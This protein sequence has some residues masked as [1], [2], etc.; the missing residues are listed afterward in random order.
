M[1]RLV[2]GVGVNDIDR[3]GKSFYYKTWANML[4]R[5]YSEAYQKDRPTYKGCTVCEEWLLFSNFRDWM[6]SFSWVG[7]HLDKDI[8]IP[9]NKVYSPETCC[10]IDQK[11]N[12]LLVKCLGTKPLG[13]TLHKP[14]GK[15]LAQIRIEGVNKYLGIFNTS[16]G[17][18][19][20]YKTEKHRILMS[21]ADGFSDERIKAGLV[22]HAEIIL[23]G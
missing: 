15:Y 7:K 20:A 17:A 22:G 10:F 13:F 5:C 18:G 14:T 19:N 16:K 6:R 21:V 4:K 3:L 23:N 1:S 11:T 8:I 12:S 9:G 2:C